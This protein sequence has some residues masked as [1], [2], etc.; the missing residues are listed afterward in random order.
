MAGRVPGPQLGGGV[1][2]D[3]EAESLYLSVPTTIRQMRDQAR[4]V[5]KA[6]EQDTIRRMA[7][8]IPGRILKCIAY[9]STTTGCGHEMSSESILDV[10]L[11]Y[12]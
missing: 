1:V 7:R 9:V 5:W 8:S 6:I 10:L 2:G 3:P 11:S 4:R 12:V